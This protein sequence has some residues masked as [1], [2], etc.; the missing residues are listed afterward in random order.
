[1][2]KPNFKLTPEVT[3]ENYAEIHIEP[4][5]KGFGHT[6]GNALRRVLLS[7]LSG[8]AP[9]QISIDGVRHQFST[10]N[11]M[12]EDVVNLLLNIKEVN[13]KLDGEGPTTV[14]LDVSGKQKVTAADL[15]TQPDLEITNPDHH[16]ATLTD[17][18]AKLKATITIERG[19]GYVTAEERD[20][21]EVGVLALDSV[22]TPV[23]SANYMVEA[24]RVGR[25]TD[26]DKLK[27]MVETNGAVTPQ[28]AVEEAASILVEY[29][30]QI[31]HPTFQEEEEG[32]SQEVKAIL[33]QPVEDL[34]LPTRITNALKKGGY[35]TLA[36]FEESTE[37]ELKEVKNIGEKSVNKVLKKLK[38]HDI[39]L[40]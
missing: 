7:N 5:E 40:E 19:T 15:K 32:Q 11:G 36:D 9:T 35:Q 28:E 10:I 31:I 13:F 1:M 30:E 2:N 8:A 39:E 16:L 37:A 27:L 22:F 38:K 18:S 17:D 25:R 12:K 34:E 33:S 26:L 24:T 23:T 4:L 29:F 20:I 14:K 6:L 3:K 21:D